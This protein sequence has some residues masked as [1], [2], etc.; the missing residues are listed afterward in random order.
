MTIEAS[1]AA[2]EETVRRVDM[3]RYLS[4]LFAPAERRPLLFALYAFNHEL[5]HIGEAAREPMAALIR[6]QWWRE[7]LEGARDGHPRAH[8]VVRGLAEMFARVGAPLELFEPLLSARAFDSGN[9]HFASLADLEAYGDATAGSVMRIA[10]RILDEHEVDDALFRHAGTAFALVGI[11][12]SL[13]LRGAR[14]QNFL[15]RALGDDRAEVV[16]A[17]AANALSHYAA[18]HAMRFPKTI[19]P[20]L[21]P[22]S[23]VPLYAKRLVAAGDGALRHTVDTPVYRRQLAMLKGAFRQRV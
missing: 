10:A 8:D 21:L 3:D 4:A 12:R 23:L 2:C 5:A 9:N 20:A 6:L 16:R 14:V 1:L 17:I 19:L 13:P 15:P 11:L 22:A 18:A 7:A